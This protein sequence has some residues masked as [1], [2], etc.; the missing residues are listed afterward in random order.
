MQLLQS[1]THQ[2]VS[3]RILRKI[4]VGSRLDAESG[5]PR[6]IIRRG[7]LLVTYIEMHDTILAAVD[8]EA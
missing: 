3:S 4:L 8:A 2:L 5:A 6:L 7:V 1:S